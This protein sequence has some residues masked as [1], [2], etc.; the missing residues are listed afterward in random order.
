MAPFMLDAPKFL[1]AGHCRF[2]VE[3][4]NLRARSDGRRDYFSYVRLALHL[5]TVEQPRWRNIVQYEVQLPDQLRG[6]T[7]AVTHTLPVEG[8]RLVRR[9]T[10]Q[11]DIVDAPA[12]GNQRSESIHRRA[13]DF[14]VL[15]IDP[16]R[17][18]LLEP[19]TADDILV[20]LARKEHVLPTAMPADPGNQR[21][22]PRRI[23]HHQRIVAAL[24][25]L[26]NR[27]RARP[28]HRSAHECVDDQ[29]A[30]FEPDVIQRNLQALA[31][32]AAGAIAGQ[33][34]ARANL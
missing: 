30:L 24:H 28:S 31:H 11:K 33:D 9:I 4:A 34:E 27:V 5:V 1:I 12:L 7:N 2:G 6:I 23:A 18:L 19:G 16:L 26:R 15:R 13:D 17:E 20:A 22:R 8:R 10:D 29:P 32:R 25:L 14:H 3:N 21:A